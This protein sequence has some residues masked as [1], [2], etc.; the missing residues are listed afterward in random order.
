MN[1]LTC[2]ARCIGVY[3]RK[4]QRTN[5]QSK[6]PSFAPPTRGNPWGTRWRSLSA[7][8]NRLNWGQL[9]LWSDFLQYHLCF[10]GSKELSGIRFGQIGWEGVTHP[11][12]RGIRFLVAPPHTCYQ[13]S[14]IVRREKHVTKLK[15]VFTG[16]LLCAEICYAGQQEHWL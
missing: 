11:I 14:S 4:S 3:L 13:H 7:N 2:K 6:F 12:Y 16:R 8:Q 15:E 1:G 5:K 9:P 10:F